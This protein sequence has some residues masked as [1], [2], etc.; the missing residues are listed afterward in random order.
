MTS[1]TVAKQY[2][3]IDQDTF[4]LGVGLIHNGE[5]YSFYDPERYFTFCYVNNIST[6]HY[7]DGDMAKPLS[8]MSPQW[9][10]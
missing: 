3:I 2:R 10:N 6:T 8:A 5:T 9:H 1:A 4:R 7:K